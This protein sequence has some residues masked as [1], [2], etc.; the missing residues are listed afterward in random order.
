MYSM[1]NTGS[2]LGWTVYS[3]LKTCPVCL[4]IWPNLAVSDVEKREIPGPSKIILRVNIVQRFAI[5]ADHIVMVLMHVGR[6]D[7][8]RGSD[9]LVRPSYHKQPHDEAK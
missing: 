7:S 8:S 2:A 6:Y 9:E 4:F 5:F 1:F 3:A